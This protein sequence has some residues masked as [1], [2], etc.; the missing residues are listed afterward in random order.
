MHSL[1][2]WLKLSLFHLAFLG[3]VTW[4]ACRFFP[5]QRAPVLA[6]AAAGAIGELISLWRRIFLAEALLVTTAV[7]GYFVW[8]PNAREEWHAFVGALMAAWLLVPSRIGWL[9]WLVPLSALEV[10]YLGINVDSPTRV[11]E[12]CSALVPIAVAALAVDAWL[13]ATSGAR[14]SGRS[15]PPPTAM[16]R[17]ALVPAAL[18]VLVG[19][20]GASAWVQQQKPAIPHPHGGEGHPAPQDHRPNLLETPSI[21]EPGRVSLDPGVAARLAWQGEPPPAGMVYLRMQVVDF[22]YFPKEHPERVSWDSWHVDTLTPTAAR[23][24]PPERQCWVFRAPGNGDLVL[25]PDDSDAVDLVE[26]LTDPEGNLYRTGLGDAPRVYRCDAGLEERVASADDKKLLQWPWAPGTTEPP[27]ERILAGQPWENMRAEDAASAIASLIQSRCR[28]SLDLPE[29]GRGHG[30][31]LRSFL[32]SDSPLER[33]GH[34]QYF[35]TAEALLLRRTFHPARLVIGYASDERDD[36]GV[37]FRALHAHAWVEFV[38]STGRWRRIDPTPGTARGQILSSYARDNQEPPVPL[39]A[40][41]WIDQVRHPPKSTGIA[42]LPR[43]GG[44]RAALVAGVVL[45]LLWLVARWVRLRPRDPR[46]AELER[47]ADDLF[48][49]ARGLG[50]RITPASTVASVSFALE[51]RTGLDLSRWRDAHLAARYGTGP[52]PEQWPYGQMKVA[53]K[54][55]GAPAPEELAGASR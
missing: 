37:T 15:R 9:R 14:A 26:M 2:T 33:V 5:D 4:Y 40:R 53:A 11:R 52:V 28:Y 44:A 36:Q 12:A 13:V 55:R 27:W 54:S 16:L 49:F 42:V 30:G 24:A 25:R 21:G 50:I 22:V 32:F 31:A 39:E 7:V 29:P 35:A 38:D 8:K 20:G 1:P 10:L 19:I 51:R 23:Q 17:W 3:A 47:R 41:N 46:R 45:V 43:S 48:A 18:C 34:C 6:F